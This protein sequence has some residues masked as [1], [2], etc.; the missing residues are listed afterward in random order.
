MESIFFVMEL[1]EIEGEVVELVVVK[2]K[3]KK[4]EKEKVKV[5]G[6]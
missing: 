3:K 2:K 1:V 6:V 4:K 5:V